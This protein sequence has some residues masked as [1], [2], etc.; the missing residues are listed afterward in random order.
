MGAWQYGA[1]DN[2]PANDVL[3]RWNERVVKNGLSPDVALNLFLEQWGDAV[4]YGDTI[5]NSEIIALLVIFLDSGLTVPQKLKK[6]AIEAINR[7]LVPSVLAAWSEPDRRKDSLLEILKKIGGR[8]APPRKPF[9]FDDP[10]LC[11]RDTGSAK[12]ALLDLATEMARTGKRGGP[13]P[14]FLRTL[15]RLMSYNIWEKDYTLYEQAQR[16]RMMMLAWY[17]GT[18]L[19]LSIKEIEELMERC[20]QWPRTPKQN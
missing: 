3:Y 6:I 1:L 14:P 11:F 9:F 15:D 16:E 2:D 8:L 4:R 19:N 12:R 18:H 7:E 17:L 20:V 10:A 13:Y 5:T